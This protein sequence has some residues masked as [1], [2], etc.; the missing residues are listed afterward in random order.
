[1]KLDEFVDSIVKEAER[2]RAH[3]RDKL[4]KDPNYPATL[5]REEW[6]DQFIAYMDEVYGEEEEG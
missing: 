2:F 6:E 1:L 3:W 5:P 4:N